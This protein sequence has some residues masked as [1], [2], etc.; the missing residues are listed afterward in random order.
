MNDVD[1]MNER[2][3]KWQKHIGKNIKENWCGIALLSNLI[4]C[5]ARFADF[6]K[7]HDAYSDIY[8]GEYW[9]GIIRIE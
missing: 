4:C 6:D 7:F 9:G 8:N 3:K 5:Q 2:I 1:E